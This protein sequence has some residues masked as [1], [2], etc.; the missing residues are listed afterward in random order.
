M[1]IGSAFGAVLLAAPATVGPALLTAGHAYCYYWSGGS[2]EGGM[3]LVAAAPTA[4]AAGPSNFIS[5][6]GGKPQDTVVYVDCV[7]GPDRIGGDA[8]IGLP[9]IDL[10]LSGDR[11][12]FNRHFVVH[13]IRHLGTTSRATMSVTVTLKG[14]AV[15]GAINGVLQVVAPG[16]LP[17]TLALVYSG[18]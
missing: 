9:R 10:H 18:H 8:Y 6:T 14:T 12:S 7:P 16:C 15:A 13:G 4:I 2:R 11:Y 5:G 17:R 1:P 3:H